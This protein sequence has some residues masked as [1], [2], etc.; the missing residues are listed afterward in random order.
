LL[1]AGRGR[2]DLLR[3]G[4]VGRLA[5]RLGAKGDQFLPD[6]LKRH[7]VPRYETNL[8]A[9]SR[10]P[11]GDGASDAGSRARHDDGAEAGVHGFSG[12]AIV[13]RRATRRSQES[14]RVRSTT[15]V[16]S[17]RMTEE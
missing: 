4:D 12:K 11:A 16:M 15:I 13:L 10:E 14:R 2:E 17:K 3:L 9:T 6:V 7:R 8:V 1:E 5:S